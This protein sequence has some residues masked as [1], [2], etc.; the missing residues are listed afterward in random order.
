MFESVRVYKKLNSI[1]WGPSTFLWSS[2]F[3][4]SQ[5]VSLFFL[6]NRLFA[7]I[8]NMQICTISHLM[9]IHL[10]LSS[11]HLCIT[12][13]LLA[14]NQTYHPT[15][16]LLSSISS[17]L[18]TYDFNH[19][20][21][22]KFFF[23]QHIMLTQTLIYGPADPIARSWTGVLTKPPHMLRFNL[24]LSPFVLSYFVYEHDILYRY[25]TFQVKISL[26]IIY[27]KKLGNASPNIISKSVTTI[28]FL[29]Y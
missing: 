28:K 9:I 19:F 6:E 21:V 27:I 1:I 18:P 4:P 20:F 5:P 29:L 25:L 16:T 8:C 11:T 17:F 3:Q 7:I 10:N 24:H 2:C 13:E 23:V 26:E 12:P 22:N 14:L 15:S